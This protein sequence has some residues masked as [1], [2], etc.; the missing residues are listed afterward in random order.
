MAAW[1]TELLNPFAGPIS[2]SP[3]LRCIA[4]GAAVA[5]YA[6]WCQRRTQTPTHAPAGGQPE[7]PAVGDRGA[8]TL[9][10][11]SGDDR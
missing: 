8:R 6:L 9:V 5:G 2:G 7:S 1:F 4:A 3:S 10:G 11:V